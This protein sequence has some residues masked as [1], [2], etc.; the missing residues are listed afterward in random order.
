MAAQPLAGPAAGTV[1]IG[2]FGGWTSASRKVK[3]MLAVRRQRVL[4]AAPS[5]SPS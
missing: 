3:V 2:V 1:K 4:A 5:P